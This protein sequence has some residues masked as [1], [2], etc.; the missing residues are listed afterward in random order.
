MRWPSHFRVP[1]GQVPSRSARRNSEDCSIEVQA[2]RVLEMMGC[3][4]GRAVVTYAD[5]DALPADVR[6]FVQERTR[7]QFFLAAGWFELLLRYCAPSG[8]TPRIYVV[9]AASDQSVECVIFTLSA[10]RSPR[11]WARKLMSL[12]NFYTMNFAPIVHADPA[13]AA[14]A[15]D[16]LA[17]AILRERPAWDVVE[18]RGLLTEA[19]TTDEIV[20]AFRR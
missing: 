11:H 17:E 20:R 9:R 2:R 4:S 14:A 18:L 3:T 5:L 12:T 16:T 13:R 7:D 19:T 8:C 15:V 6:N 1:Q 10:V